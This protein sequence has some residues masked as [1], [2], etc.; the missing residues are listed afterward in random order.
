MYG[1]KRT[2][3]PRLDALWLALLV[4]IGIIVDG[5]G[6]PSPN[7][8]SRTDAFQVCVSH[9][10]TSSWV[11]SAFGLG[12]A[13]FGVQVAGTVTYTYTTDCYKPQTAETASLINVFRQVFSS[14]IAF[15]ALPLARAIEYQYAWLVLALINVVFL[16]PL[17]YLRFNGE[18]IRESKWQIPPSFHNDT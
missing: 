14:L 18:K 8:C 5:V 15:Y 10:K 13:N 16:L 9:S 6:L 7:S 4:P 17:V 11:G 12:L 3:E 2:P 1:G